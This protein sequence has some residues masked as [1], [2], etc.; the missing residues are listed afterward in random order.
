MLSTE[1]MLQVNTEV[2][3]RV[4]PANVLNHVA[5]KFDVAGQF[6]VFHIGAQ[7]IAQHTAKVLVSRIGEKAA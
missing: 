4:V 5:D 6:T 1:A 7:Q 2:V 3:D